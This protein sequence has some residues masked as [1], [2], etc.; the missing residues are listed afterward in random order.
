[1]TMDIETR[2]AHYKE[3]VQLLDKHL[4]GE[5]MARMKQ[6]MEAAPDWENST[7]WENMDEAFRYMLTYMKQNLPD[8]HRDIMFKQL[9]KRG[10]LLNDRMLYVYRMQHAD[11]NIEV[12]RKYLVADNFPFDMTSLYAMMKKWG[13]IMKGVE[14]G[15]LDDPAGDTAIIHN[16][17]TYYSNLFNAVYTMPGWTQDDLEAALKIMDDPDVYKYDLLLLVSAVTLSLCAYYDDNKLRFLMALATNVHDYAVQARVTTGIAICCMR[18]HSLLSL[19]EGMRH[20]LEQELPLNPA[21]LDGMML[22]QKELFICQQTDLTTKKMDEEIIPAMMKSSYFRPVKFGFQHVDDYMNPKDSDPTGG[23]DS[24]R[25]DIEKKLRE[26]SDMHLNGMDVYMTTFSHLK[27]FPFFDKLANWFYPFNPYHYAVKGVYFREGK[28][29]DMLSSILQSVTFCDSDKYSFSMLLGKI[30]T[31][32]RKFIE[33]QLSAGLEGQ[34]LNELMEKYKGVRLMVEIRSYLQ[35]LYRF[36]KL[37]PMQNKHL[38]FNP[39]THDINFLHN[40]IL[41]GVLGKNECLMA[42][43]TSVYKLGNY[44]AALV[45][46]RKLVKKDGSDVTVYQRMG[47]CLQTMKRYKEAAEA[48]LKADLLKPGETWTYRQL[49]YCYRHLREYGKALDYYLKLEKS[50]PDNKSVLL[51]TGE[52]LLQEQRYEEAQQRFFKVEY[53]EPDY[54]PALRAIAWCAFISGDLGRAGKYYG[55]ILEKIEKKGAGSE[56]SEWATDYLNA[57]HTALADGRTGDAIALY[58]KYAAYSGTTDFQELW[59]DFSILSEKYGIG[60]LEMEIVLEAVKA[61]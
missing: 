56:Q 28:K 13:N 59:D 42:L 2:Y 5:A 14:A 18:H 57:G 3:T 24:E 20:R 52:C 48:Y 37:C 15:P 41:D 23:D 31:S 10:Y 61:A 16:Y 43:G 55:R 35:N 4:L 12:L 19:D 27:N 49:G 30:G 6:D 36:F 26:I 46:F 53:N 38:M 25:R 54:L 8:E 47:Y 21:F 29:V 51:R 33:S 40:T 50:D 58:K 11:D 44:E 60:R 9:I 34:D 7:E 17:E 22:V 32:E 45:Y 39:F 1:M